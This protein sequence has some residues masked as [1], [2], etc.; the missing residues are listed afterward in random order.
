MLLWVL[1]AVQ[2]VSVANAQ[3]LITPVT[4]P[5]GTARSV[6]SNLFTRITEIASIIA[7]GLAIIFLIVYGIQYITAAGDV[8]KAKKARAN[9]VNAV[10]GI[11]IFT[12]AYFIVHLAS[13]ISGLL[14]GAFGA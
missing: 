8:E 4:G 1:L 3:P 12:A 2:T 10:I 14:N 7:G 11:I 9:I 6:V 5:S 13:S